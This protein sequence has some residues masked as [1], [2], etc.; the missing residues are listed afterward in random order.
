M[1]EPICSGLVECVWAY[2]TLLAGAFAVLGAGVTAFVVWRSAS[3][4]VRIERARQKEWERRKLRLHSLE[5]SEELRLVAK[6]AKQ[7]Q[8]TVK[9][10]KASNANVTEETRRKMRLRAPSPTADWEYMS[11]LPEDVV[12]DCLQLNAL[13]EDHNFDI[14]RAGGA[15]GD[16]NFGRIIVDRLGAIQSRATK[17]S[18]I[19]LE[20]LK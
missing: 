14:E 17:L 16:D 5:I 10:H 6:R 11:L 8:S 9:V 3:L 18:N 12:R 13:I 2:Q 1:S 19:V 20:H 15:F 7:G 4:P